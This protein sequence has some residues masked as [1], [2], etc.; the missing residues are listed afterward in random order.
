MPCYN[1]KQA[2][3]NSRF[4][5]TESPLSRRQQAVERRR[6]VDEDAYREYGALSGAFRAVDE[7]KG[8]SSIEGPC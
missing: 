3:R 8:A 1:R 5:Q 7:G 2:M 4:V 6:G